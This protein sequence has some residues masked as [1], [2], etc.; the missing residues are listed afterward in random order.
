MSVRSTFLPFSKPSITED[1]VRAVADVLRSGWITTGP[2]AAEFERAACDYVGCTGAVALT[3]ATAGIHLALEA[4]NIGPGD[5]VVTPS[6]TWVS[7]ANLV[8]L[9]GA[10][11]VFC[12]IDRNT[13]MVTSQSIEAA[14]STRTRLIVPVHYAGAAVDLEPIRRLATEK[15]IAVIEDAAHAIGTEYRGERIGRRGTAIFSFHPIKNITTGEGGMFCSD[16]AGFLDRV[17]R[18]RFH[19]LGV[20]AFDRQMQGRSPQAEVLEPGYKYN[21]PDMCAVLG[22]RQLQRLEDLIS[23][24]AALATHYREKLEGIAEIRPLRDPPYPIR[25]AWHLFIVRVEAGPAGLTRDDFMDALK[26][27]NIGTGI[28][29]RAIHL[30]KYY[31]GASGGRRGTLPNTEWNSERICSLPPFPEMTPDDVDDVVRTIKEVLCKR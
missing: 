28:H 29:F 1:D 19:G 18:L 8:T 10:T 12:D 27:R 15:G 20:D 17:R 24:R 26:R 16:D 14:L 11:P 30:Q 6:M 31:A 7:L 2:K 9:R 5:E 3:S 4:L 23:K 21:L 25:H 13:L 22:L